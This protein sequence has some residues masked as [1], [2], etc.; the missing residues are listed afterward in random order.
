M[1]VFWY[2]YMEDSLGQEE[3]YMKNLKKNR[4]LMIAT[5]CIAIAVV[6]IVLVREVTRPKTIPNLSTPITATQMQERM[7]N[8]E[9]FVFYVGSETCSACKAYKPIVNEFIKETDTMIYYL[10]VAKSFKSDDEM[11]AFFKDVLGTT[12]STPQTFFVRDNKIVDYFT[13]TTSFFTLERFV[14]ANQAG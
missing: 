3:V 14:N 11:Q 8:G 10:D 5:I 1:F 6:S 13:G 9:S 7:A 4:D 12:P 2:C